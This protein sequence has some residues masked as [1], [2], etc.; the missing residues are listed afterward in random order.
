MRGAR[1]VTVL[2]RRRF[3]AALL[4]KGKG[5]ESA[6]RRAQ[7]KLDLTPEGIAKSESLAKDKEKS[8]GT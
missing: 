1:D 4:L 7:E 2:S 3:L 8:S 5:T 6:W